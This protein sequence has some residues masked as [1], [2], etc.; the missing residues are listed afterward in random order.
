MVP[1]YAIRISGRGI[2]MADITKDD[3]GYPTAFGLS[4]TDG[5]TPV[6]IKFNPSNGGMKVDTT[7]VISFTPAMRT[8]T[9]QN[10]QPV[11]KAVSDVD[12][13]VLPIYVEPATGAVLIDM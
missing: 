2:N 4:S 3:N 12:G 9:D 11:S 8:A 1:P 5:V 10:D 6:R 13:V 7:T